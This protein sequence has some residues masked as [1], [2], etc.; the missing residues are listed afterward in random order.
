MDQQESVVVWSFSQGAEFLPRA[1]HN[2]QQ[3]QLHQCL[4][5]RGPSTRARF[6][7]KRKLK[8]KPVTV[9]LIL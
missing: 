3:H 2:T 4:Q 5:F 6:P 1:R 8:N 9:T 7:R